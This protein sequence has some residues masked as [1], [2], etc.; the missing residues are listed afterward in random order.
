MAVA[1]LIRS[2]AQELPDV[3]GVAKKKKKKK[4]GKMRQMGLHQTS[5]LHI[6][7]NN[8]QSEKATY[9]IGENICKSCI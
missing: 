4:K 7:G 5:N 2:L 3:A 8:P 1:A 9:R 6:T